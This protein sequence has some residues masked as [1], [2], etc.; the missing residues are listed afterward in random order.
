M[1]SGWLAVVTVRLQFWRS[2]A[3][4]RRPP[5]T[6]V[7]CRACLPSCGFPPAR[8][9]PYQPRTTPQQATLHHW[10][11][12]PCRC[13][14]ALRSYPSRALSH[15]LSPAPTPRRYLSA[16][17]SCFAHKGKELVGFERYMA[18][19]KSGGNHCH[20]NAIAVPGASVSAQVDWSGGKETPTIVQQRYPVD[21]AVDSRDG[22][23]NPLPALTPLSHPTA[24]SAAAA[25]QAREAFEKGA[26]RHGF[27]LTHLPKVTGDAAA[28]EQLKEA[29]AWD[30]GGRGKHLGGASTRKQTTHTPSPHPSTHHHHHHHHHLPNQ[31]TIPAVGEGEY[32]VALL[33][34]GS[35]LVHPIP[36]GERF[37]LNYGREVLAE[38][39][40]EPE[41]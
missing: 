22:A 8:C 24:S 1:L 17:R 38:L 13:L 26:A 19:R 41:R 33:P 6:L 23:A 14:S 7:P 30:W 32:F 29:G 25:A 4:C 18:L 34:D 21:S 35:R 37:P 11:R 3:T 2:A 16:L 10:N 27:E 9:L 5:A 28:R 40:G 31:P 36:F 20:I 39:A 12:T 15:H